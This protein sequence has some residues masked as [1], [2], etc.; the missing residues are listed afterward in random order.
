MAPRS[1]NLRVGPT[2]RSATTRLRERPVNLRRPV[3]RGP[4]VLEAEKRQLH[5]RPVNAVSRAHRLRTTTHDLCGCARLASGDD[6]SGVGRDER[7][8]AEALGERAMLGAPEGR[9]ARLGAAH[10]AL[11]ESFNPGL[12]LCEPLARHLT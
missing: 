10:E 4:N 11:G 8:D 3:V 12:G 7:L 6:L 2:S 9:E 1:P 5:Q